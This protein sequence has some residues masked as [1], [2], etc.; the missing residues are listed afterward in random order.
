MRRCQPILM[1][2]PTPVVTPAFAVMLMFDPA[3]VPSRVPVAIVIAPLDAVPPVTF[4]V[5]IETAP[6]ATLLVPVPVPRLRA[7]EP[8][9]VVSPVL[10]LIAAEPTPEVPAP[11]VIVTVPGPVATVFP[12]VIVMSPDFPDEEPPI[13]VEI[14]TFCQSGR[15]ASSADVIVTAPPVAFVAPLRHPSG[16]MRRQPEQVRQNQP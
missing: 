9:A 1:F 6:D 16:S 3:P 10:M 11:V 15:T 5:V 7:P 13:P 4:P 2:P 12:V 14:V 8:P